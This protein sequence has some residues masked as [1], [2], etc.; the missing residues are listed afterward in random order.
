MIRVAIAYDAAEQP[1]SHEW[2]KA[3]AAGIQRCG[4]AAK[5]MPAT[6]C[7]RVDADVTVTWGLRGGRTGI[8]K[9]IQARGGRHLVLERGFLGDREKYT[10]LSFD[11]ITGRGVY[12]EPP[13]DDGGA[14][15]EAHGGRFKP[16][17][18]RDSKIAV[19]IGQ[20]RGDVTHR[21][22]NFAEWAQRTAQTLS[23]S[24]EVWFRPHPFDLARG[25]TI[26]MPEGIAIDTG[27]LSSCLERAAYV[28]TF[29]STTAVDSVLAGVPTYAAD[30]GTMAR[31]VTS[32]L[33]GEW[34][35]PERSQW[36]HELAWKQWSHDEVANG[37]AW[38]R[39]RRLI[40]T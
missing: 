34:V 39:L 31:A 17:Q 3:L 35:T 26:P 10:S 22:I 32:N 2:K 18:R 28:V 1:W 40:P 37:K 29:N 4:D 20:V 27:P 21:H 16:W 36:A 33:L 24:W 9:S 8:M 6:M 19:V 13:G 11:G 30:P 14:R 15:F 25:R 5:L 38:G 12:A 7:A 23:R